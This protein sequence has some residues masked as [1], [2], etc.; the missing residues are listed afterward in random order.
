VRLYSPQLCR[1]FT[2]CFS[3]SPQK[4]LTAKIAEKFRGDRREM[5]IA[6]GLLSALGGLSQRTLRSKAFGRSNLSIIEA[7]LRFRE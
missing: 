6:L 1:S 4:P 3:S 5:L 2:Q 7:T